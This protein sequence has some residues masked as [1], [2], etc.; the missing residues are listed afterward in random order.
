MNSERS[1]RARDPRWAWPAVAVAGLAYGWGAGHTSIETYY[2]GAVRTMSTSWHAFAFGGFD[3]AGTLTLDKLPG[4]FWVQAL[5]VRVFGLSTW[6]LVAPQIVAGVLTVIMAFGAVRRIA[7]ARA[8]VVAATITAAAPAMAIMSRGNTADAICVLLMVVAAN[9]TLRAVRNGRLRTV[10]IAGVV[11]GLAFQA[12]MIEAWAILPAL[13]LAYVIAAPG[14]L[15]RRVGRLAIACAVTVVVSLSWMTAVSLVPAADRPYVDG[16]RH[17]SVYEQVFAYNGVD[18]FGTGGTYGLRSGLPYTPSAQARAH[19]ADVRGEQSPAADSSSPGVTRLVTGEVGRDAG[20]LLPVALAGMIGLL[21][22][23]RHRPRTDI[24]RAAALLWGVWL[25]TFTVL[26]S[27]AAILLTYYTGALVPPIAALCAIALRTLYR[28]MRAHTQRSA[29]M[30]TVVPIVVGV[31]SLAAL[32]WRTPVWFQVVA[33]ATVVAGVGLLM[34]SRH[35][36]ARLRVS[37]A[38]LTLLVGPTVATVAL[39]AD[40]GGSFDAPFSAGGTLAHPSAHVRIAGYGGVVMPQ[41]TATAWQELDLVR[42]DYGG[43][44]SANRRLVIF[45]SAQASQFVLAGV[46]FVEPV[47]GY[48]GL[49]D[50]PSVGQIRDQLAAGQIAYAIVPGPYDVRARDPRIQLIEQQCEANRFAAGTTSPAGPTLYIC[51]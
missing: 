50:A 47:G 19:A 15:S 31:A 38:F 21:I 14:T 2:A 3:P 39:I 37:M 8:G 44:L 33:A 35:G 40:G 32:S 34:A 27:N 17:N 12:K 28:S 5:V 42:R 23:R 25:I 9:I 13:G 7:G 10:I 46:P 26:F 22:A 30:V 11:V 36:H 4:S 1:G 45:T 48:T 51:R 16:S 43:S 18:R 41:M 20:W 49:V 24:V 6:S 29:A